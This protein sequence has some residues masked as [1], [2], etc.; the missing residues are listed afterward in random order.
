M[1]SCFLFFRCNRLKQL[2]C[3]ADDIITGCGF[4]E[5]RVPDGVKLALAFPMHEYRTPAVIVLEGDMQRLMDIADPVAKILN[6]AS[7][8]SSLALSEERTLNPKRL[9]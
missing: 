2:G 1:R 8:S 5:A 9:R 4:N 7:F 3:G 6:D